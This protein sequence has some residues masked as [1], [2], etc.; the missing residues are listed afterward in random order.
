MKNFIMTLIAVLALTA[1]A[2]AAD[3][4]RQDFDSN[5]SWGYTSDS[6]FFNNVS[7][8]PSSPGSDTYP[9]TDGW[10]ADG[11]FGEIDIADAS[12]L[13]YAGLSGTI[14]GVNDLDDEGESWAPD[15]NA[16][17]TFAT[18]DVSN[19]ENVVIS[20]D[21]DIVGLD[22]GDEV[23]YEIFE[24]GVGLGSSTL[25]ADGEGT[26][27]YNATAGIN[28]VAMTITFV[29]NGAGDYIGVDDFAVT[30]D[31]IPEPATMALLGIGSAFVAVR[32]RR[33]A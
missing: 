17:L 6:A 4:A 19:Y 2:N 25:T 27:I 12:P 11:F 9:A 29:Q 3:I 33:N 8:T 32:R 10:D 7:S 15:D 18:V 28:D 13:D 23:S 1:A 26:L 31:V 30:G 20:F 14:L 22:S 24:N 5:T 16:T 21:Y